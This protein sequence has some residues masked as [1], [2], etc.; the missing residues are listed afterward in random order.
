M[1]D[2][3][4]LKDT[5]SAGKRVYNDVVEAIEWSPMVRI[6]KIGKDLPCEICTFYFLIF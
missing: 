1:S 5:H 2:S 6:N 3:P 4:L